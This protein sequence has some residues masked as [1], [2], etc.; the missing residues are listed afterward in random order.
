MT[1]QDVMNHWFCYI[2]RYLIVNCLLPTKINIY[3][4]LQY[5]KERVFQ[6]SGIMLKSGY[7]SKHVIEEISNFYVNKSKE[8]KR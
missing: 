3:D 7:S 5:H 8:Y 1:E 4:T 6:E 2:N